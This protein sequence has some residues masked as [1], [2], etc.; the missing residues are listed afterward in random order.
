[1]KH[2]SI[3]DRHYTYT[4][5]FSS[6]LIFDLDKTYICQLEYLQCVSVIGDN[7]G[8]FLQGQLSC[9]IDLVNEQHFCPALLCS[10]KGRIIAMM[11]VIC[12]HDY[13]LVLEKD[14]TEK[15]LSVL[16]KAA[17]ISKVQLKP[18]N[19]YQALGIIGMPGNFDLPI[20]PPTEGNN[21]SQNETACLY[22]I[23][24]NMHILLL[25]NKD[26]ESLTSKYSTLMKGSLL[27]HYLSL[28]NQRPSIYL[29]TQGLFLPH[30]LDFHRVQDMISMNKGCFRGQEIIARTHYRAKLKH[31]YCT[32]V[33]DTQPQTAEKIL[34]NEKEAG[35][36]IDWCPIDDDQF[37]IAA[38]VKTEYIDKL[39]QI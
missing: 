25:K 14:I 39:K 18:S 22:R 5:D 36:I 16:Q 24:N 29:Q 2:V 33:S 12:C 35:E 21:L 1:M 9:N 17:M 4:K 13:Q 20:H 7:A 28:K 6:E 26:A 11:D 15:T 37:L 8:K 19:N 32:Y 30:R 34:Y 31:Q 10:L 3:N 27:W 23:A 38:S